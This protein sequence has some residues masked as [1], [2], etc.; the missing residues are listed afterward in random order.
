MKWPLYFFEG[1]ELAIFMIA[2]CVSTVLLFDPAL[3][4]V[5]MVPSAAVRRILMGIA[6]GVTAILIIRSPMG[7][8]SGAHFNPAIT[9]TYLRLGKIAAAD[10]LFY[11]IFQFAGGIVRCRDFGA[12]SG[13]PNRGPNSRLCGHGS[14]RVRAPLQHSSR[15]SLCQSF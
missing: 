14:R 4:I 2:A 1:A 7:K 12:Y 15:S 8:R 11:I 3:P 13:E 5:H 6:M 9:L 10:S